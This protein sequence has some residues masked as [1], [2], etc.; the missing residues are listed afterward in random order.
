MHDV[1]MA[2]PTL[3]LPCILAAASAVL[4]SPLFCDAH[5]KTSGKSADIVN[6]PL[7]TTKLNAKRTLIVGPNDEFKTI[8]SAIDAVPV[9]NYEWII[10]HLR[11]GIYTCVRT[12]VQAWCVGCLICWLVD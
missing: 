7:L 1:P 2:R 10:V 3:L 5:G 12:Y 4:S 8:Q 9:G 11:S 6:G